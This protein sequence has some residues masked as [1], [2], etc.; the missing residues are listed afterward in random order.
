MHA[1]RCLASTTPTGPATRH[2]T[3]PFSGSLMHPTRQHP[4]TRAPRLS[5]GPLDQELLGAVRESIAYD[6]IPR[7][8]E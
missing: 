6:S 1:N 4:A 3:Q 7:Q 2:V 5:P 8:V